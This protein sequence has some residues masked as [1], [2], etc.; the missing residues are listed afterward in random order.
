M[1]RWWKVIRGM[2]GTGLTFSAG[3]G[4]VS[5]VLAGLVAL[6]PGSQGGI[7]LARLVVASTIWAF[8]IGVAFSGFLAMSARG[9]TF[10]SLSLPRFALLG[11]G[12]GLL[13]YAP[14]AANAWQA[15]D[16]PTALVNAAILVGLGA[17]SATATLLLAR[18]A[19]PALTSDEE[20]LALTEGGGAGDAS[21][22]IHLESPR[23]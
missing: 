14:L 7:E 18:R 12:G 13:L 1:S 3:V 19:R 17:G 15:W 9:R 2:I 4:V 21:A 16:T 22:P 11:A 6:L 5:A 8:P 10:E 20:A 23:V